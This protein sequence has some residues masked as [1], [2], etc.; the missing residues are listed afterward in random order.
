[1]CG[2]WNC[3][4]WGHILSVVL[5]PILWVW[6]VDIFIRMRNAYILFECVMPI[7]SSKTNYKISIVPKVNKIYVFEPIFIF[8]HFWHNKI[9]YKVRKRSFSDF[10]HYS[11]GKTFPMFRN[12]CF[13]SIER[14]LHCSGHVS[15]RDILAT[16]F[17]DAKSDNLLPWISKIIRVLTN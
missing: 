13:C 16:C 4:G 12:D 6:H 17:C 14:R 11:I 9:M 8:K 1:M 7:F 5:W 2:C 10:A 15:G 3:S